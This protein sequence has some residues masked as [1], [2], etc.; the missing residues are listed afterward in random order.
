MR[1]F[2]HRWIG[3]HGVGRFA[4]ELAAALPG[5]QPLPLGGSPVSPLDPFKLAFRL[6]GRARFFL[7]PG[8]NA[9]IQKVCRYG[10]CVH[11]LNHIHAPQSRDAFKHLYYRKVIRPAV[12]NADVVFSVSEYSADAIAEWARI[13]RERVI[14]VG[15]GV[16]PEFVTEG[17]RQDRI[18]PYLLYVGNRMA[19]KNLPRLLRAFAMADIGAEWKLVLS[20][21]PDSSMD[22]MVSGASLTGRVEFTGLVSDRELAAWYRGARALVLVS[23]Y[24]GFGLPIVESMACGTP[25]ITSNTTAMP[26]V[27]GDA[28]LL[29]DPSDVEKISS[30]I[31]RITADGELCKLLRDKGL[32]RA[33]TFTWSSTVHKVHHQLEELQL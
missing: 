28:A 26:E 14:N 19:H 2:D 23:Q 24:E 32:S 29:V 15:N 21:E 20:G 3:P 11:D 10:V 13:S 31:S 30:S 1:F 33:A 16:S 25:V 8:F 6:R 12:R 9:P 17:P 22:R 7:S 27:A 5:F 4:Q 18:Y